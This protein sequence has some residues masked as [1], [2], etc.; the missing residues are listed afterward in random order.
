MD[1]ATNGSSIRGIEVRNAAKLSVLEVPLKFIGLPGTTQQPA[2]HRKATCVHM[3]IK[4]ENAG[5]ANCQHIAA[6][7]CCALASHEHGVID[8]RL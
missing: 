6:C 1:E 2:I 7:G 3:T 5:L 4:R 8:D